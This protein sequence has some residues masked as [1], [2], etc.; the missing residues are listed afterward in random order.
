MPKSLGQIHT[1]EY[2]HTVTSPPGGGNAGQSNLLLDLSGVLTD[3]LQHMVRC[4]GNTFKMVGVD[5]AAELSD[6]TGSD[7][8]SVS[9]SGVLRYYAPTAGRCAAMREAWEATKRAFKLQGINYR[10]NQNYDWRPLI[11]SGLS[12]AGDFKNQAS[13]EVLSGSPTPLYIKDQSASTT[14]IFENWNNSVGNQ[15]VGAPDFSVGWNIMQNTVEQDYVLNEG[16]YLKAGGRMYADESFEEI[17]FQIALDLEGGQASTTFQFRPDPALYQSI[18]AG[19]IIFIC[20][21]VVFSNVNAGNTPTLDLNIS[22]YVSGWKSIMSQS[23]HF[24]RMHD[25]RKYG[26]RSR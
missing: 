6:T 10:S 14:G 13:I 12:N 5:I 23:K 7:P 25:M 18:L 19:Q 17:P 3:Q 16:S 26:N 2:V 1:C 15:Q 9:L 21:D 11:Q 20:E 8:A 4:G 22:V 24:N